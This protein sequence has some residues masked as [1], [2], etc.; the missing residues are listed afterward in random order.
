MNKNEFKSIVKKAAKFRYKTIFDFA[1]SDLENY[2]IVRNDTIA[3]I[4]YG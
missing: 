1:I 2:E 4:L 3:I